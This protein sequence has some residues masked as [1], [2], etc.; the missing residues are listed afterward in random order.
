MPFFLHE[1]IK[2]LRKNNANF[3]KTINDK[4][5]LHFTFF[6]ILCFVKDG[7]NKPGAFFGG[8]FPQ[9][10]KP[11]HCSQRAFRSEYSS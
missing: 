5:I 3:D 7:I 1:N 9:K 10:S 11:Q 6:S 2:K 8:I 4:N